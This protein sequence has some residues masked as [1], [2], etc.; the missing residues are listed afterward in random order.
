MK[1]LIV[2]DQYEDKAKIVADILNRI[3]ES[4]FDLVVDAKT[5]I[6]SMSYV[7]YDLLI[8]DLQIPEVLGEDAKNDGGTQLLKYIELNEAIKKPTVVLGITSHKDAY[9]SCLPFFQKRGWSLIL[10]VDDQEHI[11]SV[12]KTMKVHVTTLENKF[13]IVFLTAL[14]H[15]EYEAVMNLPIEWK[16][17]QEINDD[18]VYHTSNIVTA[19]GISRSVIATSL[20]HMGIAA[21]AA[22]TASLCVKFK[23]S[24]IVMT[25]ICA[26]IMGR[27]NLGDIL[28]ADPTWDWGSGKLT[29]VDGVAKFL[30]QPTQIALE[31]SIRRKIQ[32]L[33]TSNTYMNEIYSAWTG[34]RP[35]H[36]PKVHIGP[37][38][39]GAVVL[40][41]PITVDLIKTQ[42]RATNGIEMEAFG[43]MAAA[44]YSGPNRP[45]VLI[46]KSVC[47]FANPEKNDAWQHYAAYT[48]AQFA[49][50]FV[51]ND[52]IL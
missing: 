43:V 29:I 31:P 42:N 49:Y 36:N 25:G 7:K 5:A 8:L 19:D 27:V 51:K 2:D 41:D 24:L 46:A 16:E 38:A 21:A 37:M 34:N 4:D 10:G 47:D 1:T 40:E 6:K 52:I 26:G 18:N 17:H 32:Y 13:D 35:Q 14:P 48:S 9:D 39:T 30:S 28:I 12:L 50:Q 44:Y 33:S 23:P 15:T 45:K 11:L 3:D 22:T 20:P